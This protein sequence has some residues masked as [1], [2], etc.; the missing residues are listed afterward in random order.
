MLVSFEKE[1]NR[2]GIKIEDRNGKISKRREHKDVSLV[3][4][5]VSLSL[6]YTRKGKSVLL[7]SRAVS[8]LMVFWINQF[9]LGKGLLSAKH[10]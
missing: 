6:Q 5:D 7:L 2:L 3:L 10:W 8:F 1:T 4:Y 9:H